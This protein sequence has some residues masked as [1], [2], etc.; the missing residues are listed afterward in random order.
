MELPLPLWER[1][2]ERGPV[3]VRAPRAPQQ[4]DEKGDDFRTRTQRATLRV[5]FTL[6]QAD[7][8]YVQR[9][10]VEKSAAAIDVEVIAQPEPDLRVSDYRIA[11]ER[12]VLDFEYG[13]FPVIEVAK[14]LCVQPVR[15]GSITFQGWPPVFQFQLSGDGLAFGKRR[16]PVSVAGPWQPPVSA[17]RRLSFEPQRQH[18]V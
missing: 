4:G 10:P 17:T 6:Q 15:V 13:W 9:V 1:A 14:R 18:Q 5:Q 2:G 7:S 3:V 16:L 8:L 11:T 12:L